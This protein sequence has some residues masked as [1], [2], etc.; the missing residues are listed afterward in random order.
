M[1]PR[2]CRP[3]RLA[4]LRGLP[5]PAA[6]P[7]IAAVAGERRW[8]ALHLPDLPTDRL[9]RRDPALD[10][11]P[12]ALW[13]ADG[14][15]RR[16]TAVSPPGRAAGLAAGMAVADAQ[17]MLPDLVLFPADPA[18]D[19]A[20][21]AALAAWARRWTP[22]AAA[23]PPDGLLLDITGA[24]HLVGGEALLLEQAQSRLGRAG[25]AVHGAI[26]GTAAAAG[27]LA[28]AGCETIVPPGGEAEAI[29]P[30]PLAC[31][32]LDP[33]TVAGFARFGLLRAGD[34]LAQPRAGL[35]RRLGAEPLAAL[36]A[37]LGRH[38]APAQPVQPRLPGRAD[39]T[40]PEPLLTAEALE[41]GIDRLA[42]ALCADLRAAGEGARAVV[43]ECRRVDD[44]V[45]RIG[46]GLGTASRDPAHLARLL[47]GRVER[48]DPGFG[49]AHMALIATRAEPLAA[50]QT[51]LPGSVAADAS[52]REALAPL[53]DRLTQRLGRGNVFARVPVASHIPHRATRPADPHAPMPATPPGWAARPRPVRLLTRPSPVAVIALLPDGPPAR[54]GRQRVVRAEGP[55]R[56]GGEWWAED[57]PEEDYWRVET[58][59]GVRLWLARREGAWSLRGYFP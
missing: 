17:A 7:E 35:M 40:C 49:I 47:R 41:I 46:L 15:A 24:A 27:A 48:I 36:D 20:L 51:G 55:E 53:L 23:S 56:I 26:A 30:L 1:R 12:F 25:F 3:P 9:A 6:P 18:A 57:A 54:V 29:A 59:T 43:L 14:S 16:L 21:L 28:R 4:G 58:E 32:R 10:G 37:A 19:A 42:A 52:R 33:D 34:A 5:P 38:V 11:R 50:A 13:A 2:A 44:T 8:L 39:L 45:Q 31:F 22:L